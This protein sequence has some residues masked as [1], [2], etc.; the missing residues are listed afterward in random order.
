MFSNLSHPSPF[1]F[2]FVDIYDHGLGPHLDFTYSVLLGMNF[3]DTDVIVHCTYFVAHFQVSPSR[4]C[5]GWRLLMIRILNDS[6][7]I[8]FSSK[9]K[10]TKG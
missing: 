2:P 3:T 10:Y 9:N 4:S 7:N 1:S 5:E 8:C 6:R